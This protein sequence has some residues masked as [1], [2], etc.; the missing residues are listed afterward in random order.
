MLEYFVVGEAQDV[1]AQFLQIVGAAPIV[2]SLLDVEVVFAINFNNEPG[3][4]A[5]KV[6]NVA[7]NSVLPA[8]AWPHLI[9]PHQLPQG[10]LRF[11]S[12]TAICPG[13]IF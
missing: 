4:Q 3:G 5:D 9:A 12:F 6:D 8:K 7:L 11:S 13:V 10:V 2:V 1:E